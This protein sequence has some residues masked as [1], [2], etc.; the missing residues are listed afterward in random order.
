MQ[1]SDISGRSPTVTHRLHIDFYREELTLNYTK[2]SPGTS[3]RWA[4]RLAV[5]LAI[6]VGF[7]VPAQAQSMQS[8]TDK[9]NQLQTSLNLFAAAVATQLSSIGNKIDD[10]LAKLNAPAVPM[11]LTAGPIEVRTGETARCAMLNTGTTPGAAT[12]TLYRDATYVGL[13]SQTN[14][15]LGTGGGVGFTAS[16]SVYA[17]CRLERGTTGAYFHATLTVY[18]ALQN[19][20]VVLQAQ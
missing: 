8:I 9:L 13:T 18:D 14:G 3:A 6:S 11:I 15:G 1:Q 2:K 20:L 4:T 10:V 16:T 7:T 19:K 17:F 5:A 12:A